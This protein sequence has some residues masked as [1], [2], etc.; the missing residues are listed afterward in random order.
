MSQFLKKYDCVLCNFSIIDINGEIIRDKYYESNPIRKGFFLSVVNPCFGCC[1]AFS[2][3]VLKNVLP[4][5][6]KLIAHD[7]WISSFSSVKFKLYFVLDTLHYYRRTG[8]NVSN[9]A[10]NGKSNNP[11][12]FKVIYRLRMLMQL[13]GRLI[14]FSPII[15]R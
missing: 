8:E 5:P 12:Y 10:T 2:K 3:E 1:M 6:R 11:F 13:L 15:R 4:F 9:S 14:K 7:K